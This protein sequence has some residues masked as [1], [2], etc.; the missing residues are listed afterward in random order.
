MAC[1][2]GHRKIAAFLLQKDPE[3]MNL[4]LPTV[5]FSL[6]KKIKIIVLLFSLFLFFFFFFSLEQ[7]FIWLVLRAKK[8]L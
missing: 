2:H 8:K 7:D 4:D 5:R 6:K 1:F 3:I